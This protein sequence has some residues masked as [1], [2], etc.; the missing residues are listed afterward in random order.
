MVIS[1][2]NITNF[3]ITASSSYDLST[4]IL[5]TITAIVQVQ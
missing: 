2:D 1:S 3:G 5:S 4:G